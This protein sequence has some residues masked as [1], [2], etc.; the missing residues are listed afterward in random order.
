MKK[1]T[2]LCIVGIA[3]SL[4]LPSSS[5]AFEMDKYNYYRDAVEGSR[6][7]IDKNNQVID[8]NL[9]SIDDL[10][11]DYN[12]IP[13]NSNHPYWWE[14]HQKNGDCRRCT[15]NKAWVQHYKPKIS[16]LTK[17]NKKLGAENKQLQQ[18]IDENKTYWDAWSKAKKLYDRIGETKK[19]KTG[20]NSSNDKSGSSTSS[21][22]EMR[23][24]FGKETSPVFKRGKDAQQSMQGF[25]D[26]D[27]IV[28]EPYQKRY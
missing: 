13:G 18:R 27:H 17:E 9:Q 26:N 21:Q 11:A 12:S 28:I 16:R 3:V 4:L 25:I 1:E 20:K 6:A 22:N 23:K 8:L 15:E 19:D 14:Y 10:M 7:K 5:F 2:V 24:M